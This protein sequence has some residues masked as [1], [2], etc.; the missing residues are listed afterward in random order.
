VLI[1]GAANGLGRAHAELLA[2]RGASV[3]VNDVG[4]TTDEQGVCRP[5]A[6][7]TVEAIVAA[8]GKAVADGN[9]IST[10]DGAEALVAHAL[11]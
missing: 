11:D 7:V 9:D 2:R 4:T 3:V 10:R 6:D 8:G 5:A 1:T